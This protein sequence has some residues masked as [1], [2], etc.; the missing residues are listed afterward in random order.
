MAAD[1]L[2]PKS[3]APTLSSRCSFFFCVMPLFFLIKILRL[4]EIV[5]FPF[6]RSCFFQI[7]KISVLI[8]LSFSH[9]LRPY[10]FFFCFFY[11]FIL[12]CLWAYYPTK[13]C[14]PFCARRANVAFKRCN[15][16]L[17][18]T[19]RWSNTQFSEWDIVRSVL[20]CRCTTAARL[21]CVCYLPG[22]G[23][24]LYHFVIILIE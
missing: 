24:F 12:R 13:L 19:S 1:N 2:I 20:D 6:G 14:L 9:A 23:C 8:F 17:D 15:D 21:L 10:L 11:P 4:L 5:Y 22:K 7:Q 18:E 16:F 3:P